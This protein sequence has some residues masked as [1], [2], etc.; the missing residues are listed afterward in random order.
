MKTCIVMTSRVRSPAKP[1]GT[2][3]KLHSKKLSH[4]VTI[5]P[6][7]IPRNCLT[8]FVNVSNVSFRGGSVLVSQFEGRSPFI[9]ASQLFNHCVLQMTRFGSGMAGLQFI[10]SF[11]C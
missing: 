10:A 11:S 8:L 4:T 9:R 3:S 7:Y 2:Q 1:A 6:S 5:S